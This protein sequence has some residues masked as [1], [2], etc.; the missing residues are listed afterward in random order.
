MEILS[1]VKTVLLDEN[2][3]PGNFL[4]IGQFDFPGIGSTLLCLDIC[5]QVNDKP[6]MGADIEDGNWICMIVIGKS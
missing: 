2:D 6:E 5:L 4:Q 1:S 3:S